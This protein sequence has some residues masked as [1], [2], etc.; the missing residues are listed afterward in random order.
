MSNKTYRDKAR[1]IAVQE[2]MD[3]Q[4]EDGSSISN[5]Y[6]KMPSKTYR[7][8]ARQVADQEDETLSKLFYFL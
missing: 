6:R 1:L 5:G 3:A 2:E 7:D 4:F 8:K